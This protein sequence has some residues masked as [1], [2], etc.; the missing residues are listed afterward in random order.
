MYLVSNIFDTC[1]GYRSVW[2][3]QISGNAEHDHE[4]GKLGEV[5]FGIMKMIWEC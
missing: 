4:L 3:S 1:I 5:S 2:E